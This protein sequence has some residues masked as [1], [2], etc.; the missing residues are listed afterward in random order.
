MKN[1]AADKAEFALEVERREDLVRA[2][3]EALKPGA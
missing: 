1:V 2:M 3:T